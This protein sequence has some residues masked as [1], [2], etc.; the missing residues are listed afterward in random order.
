MEQRSNSSN[1]SR[2]DCTFADD[3]FY[4]DFYQNMMYVE[5]AVYVILPFV[6]LITA[7]SVLAWKLRSSVKEARK[8]LT[9]TTTRVGNH[10]NADTRS[11]T[12]STVTLTVMV[13]SLTYEVLTLPSGVY[14]LM[15]YLARRLMQPATPEEVARQHMFWAVAWMLYYLNHSINFYLYILTGRRFRLEFIRIITCA[16]KKVTTSHVTAPPH[17]AVDL[18]SNSGRSSDFQMRT[19]GTLENKIVVRL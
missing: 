7:N 17:S 9:M 19:I 3:T 11:K 14:F 15:F 4:A 10:S 8:T 12:A 18:S 1:Y 13:V 2:T 5:I 6:C 16:R